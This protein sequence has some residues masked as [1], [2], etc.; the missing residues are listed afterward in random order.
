MD[1]ELLKQLDENKI[2]LLIVDPEHYSETNIDILSYLVKKGLYGIYVT[3]N[4]PYTALVELLNKEKIKTENL[5]FIDLI[6]KEFNRHITD[7]QGCIYL[8]SPHCLTD[9]A[10]TLRHAVET[11]KKEKF[12]F[13][14]SLSTLLIYNKIE[15]ISRFAHFLTGKMR[16][17]D[18][19]GIIITLNKETDETLISRLSQFCDSIYHIKND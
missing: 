13:L 9:L 2:I 19:K 10:I 17:W 14:D 1:K 8:D 18:T 15:T 5:F 3:V 11:V 16:M 4:K 12:I 6:T 7:T